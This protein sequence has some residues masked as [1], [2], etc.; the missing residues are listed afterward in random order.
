M[1]NQLLN[2]MSMMAPQTGNVLFVASL[3]A[4]SFVWALHSFL[5]LPSYG[6]TSVSCPSVPLNRVANGLSVEEEAYRNNRTAKASESLAEWFIG[7]NTGHAP[8]EVFPTDNMPTIGLASSG[9]SVRA[10]LVGAGVI[11][12]MD[13]RD[14]SAANPSLKGL[15][16]G[17]S[18]HSGLDGGS[19]LV[20]ALARNPGATVSSLNAD[21]WVSIP[22]LPKSYRE[23]FSTSCLRRIVRLCCRLSCACVAPNHLICLIPK[24]HI[25]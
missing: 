8:A 22:F 17:I 13:N 9:G 18:Y 16:Q 7:I 20:A 25:L 4:C 14:P 1:C 15:W 12:A 6:P 21:K 5:N 3:L 24:Q 23:D 10:L 19:W 11:Q 2:A